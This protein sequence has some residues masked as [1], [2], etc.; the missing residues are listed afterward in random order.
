[1]SADHEDFLTEDQPIPSQKFVLLSFL[2]PEK[3]LTNKDLFF[4]E[5][6]LKTFEFNFRVQ[7]FETFLLTTLREINDKL[8][9][10]ADKAEA[11]DLSGVAQ[12]IRSSRVRLDTVMDSLKTYMKNN[13]SD[14]KASK[15]KE[16]YDDFISQNREKLEDDFYAKND[17]RT[18]V[19]G[20]KVRGVFATQ[21]EAVARSKRLQRQDTLHNIFVGEVGKWLPWDPEPSQVKNQEY[22]EDQLNTLMKKYSENEEARQAFEAEQREKKRKAASQRPAVAGPTDATEVVA[23]PQVSGEV[24]TLPPEFSS[25]FAGDGPADLAIQRKMERDA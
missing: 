9:T 23:A 20:L 21:D 15:L 2:S 14:L 22:A 4:F 1:M 6:F 25:M 17:F 7:S 10:E 24:A 19:R 18:T 16:F 11:D 12:T 8:T 3:V 5:T 13:Q